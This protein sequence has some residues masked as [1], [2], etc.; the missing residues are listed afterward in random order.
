MANNNIESEGGQSLGCMLEINSSLVDLDVSLNRLNDEGGKTLIE[1]LKQNVSLRS[2]KVASN[3]LSSQSIVALVKVIQKPSSSELNQCNTTA[4][5]D[6]DLS[7]NC[8]SDEDL[9]RLT[10]A[11]QMN[12]TLMSM[13]IR[14]QV[15]AN[16]AASSRKS[17]VF[18]NAVDTIHNRLM[19][20]A[21]MK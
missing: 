12:N 20:N 14:S 11:V 10:K 16:G 7:A 4:L 6:I 8:L 21:Q 19:K 5:E 18:E 1:G 15:D 13:D 9:I 17:L 2:L 3:S